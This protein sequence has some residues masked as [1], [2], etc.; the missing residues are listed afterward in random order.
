MVETKIFK[1]GISLL[2]ATFL[3]IWYDDDSEIGKGDSQIW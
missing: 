3:R 1:R 2:D